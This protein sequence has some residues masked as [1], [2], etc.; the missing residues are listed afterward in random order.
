MPILFLIVV[1]ILTND[2]EYGPN[3]IILILKSIK[4]TYN[5]F[6][7]IHDYW[8]KSAAN[9]FMN[10]KKELKILNF[11]RTWDRDT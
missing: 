6:Y 2:S 11:I 10:A 4:F 5:F 7:I 8:E 9:V 1:W 3:L